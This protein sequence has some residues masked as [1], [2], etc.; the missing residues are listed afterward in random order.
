VDYDVPNWTPIVPTADAYAKS[1]DVGRHGNIGLSL[2]HLFGYRS[3]YSHLSSYAQ[4]IDR[5]PDVSG[6]DSGKLHKLLLEKPE[7]NKLMI[8]ALSGATG[9]GPEALGGY[10]P[11]HLDFHIR[12]REGGR[13]IP[14][15][16]DPFK[17]GIDQKKPVG[18]HDKWDVP[19]GSRPVYW[20]GKME[21]DH[22]GRRTELLQ[23][24]LDTLAKR[25]KESGL[26]NATKDEL[27]KRQNNPLELRDY[28]GMRVLEKKTGQD[29]QPRYEF[30]PG[31]LMYALM[32]EFY[33]RTS[34]HDFVAMLPF[35]FPPLKHI[36]QEANPNVRF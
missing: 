6:M 15:G 35:I 9:R 26:D 23:K 36:Y 11:P 8:V 32:L 4:V 21:I 10:I 19:Y 18:G 13:N 20:D 7:V 17:L 29:G 12:I 22:Y 33:N 5:M 1:T 30:M 25:V 2:V 3:V 14:P 16:I 24:S 28:L 31:S 27:L 34:R